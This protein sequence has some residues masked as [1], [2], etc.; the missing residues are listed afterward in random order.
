MSKYSVKKVFGNLEAP[1]SSIGAYAFI[2][3][4]KQ[5]NHTALKINYKNS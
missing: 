2:Q 3:S 4:I 1:L 5:R